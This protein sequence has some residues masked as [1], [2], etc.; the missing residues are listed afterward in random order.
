M[1]VRRPAVAGQ[2]Y[3]SDR[4]Q[5][6]TE[7]REAFLGPTGPGKLPPGTFDGEIIATVNPHAGYEYSGGFAAN[8]FYALSSKKRIDLAVVVGPNHYGLGSGVAVPQSDEWETPLGK[9]GID[10]QA[11]KRL[12]VESHLVDMD[13]AAHWKEHSIEV[14][15]P[16]LQFTFGSAFKLLPI[17]MAMQDMPTA[18]EVG[19]HIAGMIK[20][21]N[22]VL[23]ASSDFT[24]YEPGPVAS[25]KDHE[26][27]EKILSF[28]VAG[29]Y[30][31]IE[32]HD[33]TMC[34][35]GPV[36]AVMTAA[37]QLGADKAKLLRYGS[38]GDVTGDY[39]SVV[40]YGSVAFYK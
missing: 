25:E 32:K 24:H 17:S 37:K 22:F 35:Y 14:Q 18:I 16:F 3:P 27:L 30:R 29:L 6:E 12:M 9:V 28:D 8:S 13:D 4:S 39:S 40:G 26:A 31:V 19:D 1:R 23:I 15:V 11:A 38:S 33:I 36:A 10:L 20:D 21:R 7:I 5:L 2:F 34:G